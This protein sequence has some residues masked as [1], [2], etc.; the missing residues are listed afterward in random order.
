VK[1]F[2]NEV[3]ILWSFLLSCFPSD[4]L[5]NTELVGILHFREQMPE[6]PEGTSTK[7]S[8]CCIESFASP[9][10]LPLPP[11]AAVWS[12]LYLDSVQDV[13]TAKGLLLK[14]I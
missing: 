2:H 9:P 7:S 11:E 13:K 10:V 8:D 1:V 6:F 12:L 5:G 14:E 3:C 4:I